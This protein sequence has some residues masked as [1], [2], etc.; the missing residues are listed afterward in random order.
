MSRCATLARRASKGE[1][2]EIPRW[3]FELVYGMHLSRETSRTLQFSWVGL[4]M[5]RDAIKQLHLHPPPS[6]KPA[7]EA[8]IGGKGGILGNQ[9]LEASTIGRERPCV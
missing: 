5:H 9:R 3:R 7:A 8:Q 4:T 1:S 6:M 2:P